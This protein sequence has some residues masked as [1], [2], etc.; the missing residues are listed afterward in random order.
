MSQAFHDA[1]L[2]EDEA[3][4]R[5]RETRQQDRS[6]VSVAPRIGRDEGSVQKLSNKNAL[7]EHEIRQ[8]RW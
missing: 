8:A 7:D 2:A 4:V 3:G 1:E 5:F 6:W